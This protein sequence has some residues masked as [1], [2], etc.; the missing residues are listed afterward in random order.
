MYF[1]ISKNVKKT[2]KNESFP[3]NRKTSDDLLSRAAARQVPSAQKGLTTVFEMG[4]GVT[5]SLLSLDISIK[6]I[7]GLVILTDNS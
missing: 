7:G 5:P 1:Y 6:L 2:H 4:T 3:K